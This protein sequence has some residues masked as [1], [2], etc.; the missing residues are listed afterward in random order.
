MKRLIANTKFQSPD[1]LIYVGQVSDHETWGGLFGYD[2]QIDSYSDEFKDAVIEIVNKQKKERNKK[3]LPLKN[4]TN[5]ADKVI[6]DF[7]SPYNHSYFPEYV[8]KYSDIFDGKYYIDYTDLYR[9]TEMF[10][11][12]DNQVNNYKKLIKSSPYYISEDK[13]GQLNLIPNQVIFDLLNPDIDSAYSHATLD[14]VDHA[15]Q[16]KDYINHVFFTF[17]PVDK[18]SAETMLKEINKLAWNQDITDYL[19]SQEEI[20]WRE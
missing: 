15:I 8:L 14:Y 20:L 10:G 18:K 16:Y 13:D 5:D 6:K 4:Y 17:Y 3:G 1:D 9:L 11:G 19:L 12:V 2:H 7:I